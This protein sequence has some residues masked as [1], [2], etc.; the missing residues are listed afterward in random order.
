[1]ASLGPATT[2]RP[3][4]SATNWF[5]RALREPPPTMWITSIF[6]LPSVSRLSIT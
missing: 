2:R 5:S 1:V 4:Q 6:R 3:V